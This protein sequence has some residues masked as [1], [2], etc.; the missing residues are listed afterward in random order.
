[1]N[2]EDFKSFR[3]VLK[4]S[5]V[6]SIPTHS[7]QIMPGI[8]ALVAS[9]VIVSAAG[10]GGTNGA[11]DS[12]GTAPKAA[13]KSSAPVLV[14]SAFQRAVRSAVFPAWGQLTNGKS[15]K[16]V[17]LLSVQ[18][19]LMTRIVGESRAA[20]AA[21]RR[22]DE[23]RS[24]A[25]TD[26]VAAAEFQRAHALAQDHFDTRREMLFWAFLGGFYGAM[27]AYVDAHIGNFGE[28]LESGR[29]LFADADPLARSV[30]VG[31]RF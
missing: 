18:T 15:K 23:F 25:A 30:E 1:M 19:Y 24:V 8:V 31:V 22:A 17:V 6:G 20:S 14:P 7:R 16:A 10:A 27:D 4:P 28:E 5:E 26:L 13:V 29:K 3:R 11:A 9:L 21:Q 2:L 12:S